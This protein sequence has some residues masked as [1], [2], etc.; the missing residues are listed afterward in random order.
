MRRW[1]GLTMPGM[2]AKLLA[3][4]DG[5]G[6]RRAGTR[7]DHECATWLADLLREARIEHDSVA[8]PLQTRSV[9]EAFLELD[10]LRIDGLPLFDGPDTSELGVHGAL[11]P[12]DAACEIGFLS[13]DPG[14]ASIKGQPLEALRS[15]S[16]HRALI[17]ATNGA[18]G[19]L[20]PVNAQYFTVPF[21]PPG[22]QVAGIH[23]D[24]LRDSAARR[25]MARVVVRS[26]RT[27][28]TSANL[29]ARIGAAPQVVLLTPRTSWYESTA[30]RAG[31]VIAWLAGLTHAARNRIAVRGFATCGHELGHLGL[32]RVL[33][34]HAALVRE[35]PLWIHLGANLGC[36]SD[37]RLTVRASNPHDATRLREHL[38]AN[39]YP[40]ALIKV[41]P[42]DQAMGEARDL[43]LHGARVLSMIGR[44]AHFHA[45]SDRWPGNV[46]AGWVASIAAAVCAWLD[47]TA[48]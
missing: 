27:P 8:V 31:G 48:R 42:I 4:Y 40:G 20:A 37:G 6:L 43:A 47:G 14:A 44:N 45:P 12:A 10:G 34:D 9:L 38:V 32:E 36:A 13:V 41:E 30:E 39:H 7:G 26:D 21:G 29:V 19:S 2:V 24:H 23:A 17:L 5:F 1:N 3:D 25:S 35:A 28:G 11:G 46:N 15:A 22:L 18:A 16:T 33:H